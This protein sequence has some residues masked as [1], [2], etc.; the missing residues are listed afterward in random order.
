[1]IER[2]LP[3][4]L[5][6]LPDELCITFRPCILGGKFL[7]SITGIEEDFLPRGIVL[8]LLKVERTADGIRTR[9]RVRGTRL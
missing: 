6:P 7:P 8:D 1:M 9:Y 4:E 2:R 5:K 3:Q